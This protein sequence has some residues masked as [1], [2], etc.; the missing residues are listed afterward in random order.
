M[1]QNLGP[2]GKPN[3]P[4]ITTVVGKYFKEKM[5]VVKRHKTD[6][7]NSLFYITLCSI[8]VHT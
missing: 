6:N 1:Y 2:T 3:K 8:H 4:Y 7:R 5:S